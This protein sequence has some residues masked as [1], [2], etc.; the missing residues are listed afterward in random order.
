MKKLISELLGTLILLNLFSSCASQ[1]SPDEIYNDVSSMM[2]KEAAFDHIMSRNR[3]NLTRCYRDGMKGKII[4]GNHQ[5]QYII[6]TGNFGGV[7][8]SKLISSELK[9]PEIEECMM[10]TFYLLKFPQEPNTD[11]RYRVNTSQL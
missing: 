10:K 6:F 1:Q 7:T 9:M 2:S 4:E 5:I 8:E 3:A 11:I